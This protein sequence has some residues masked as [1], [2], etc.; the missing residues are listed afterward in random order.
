MSSIFVYSPLRYPGGKAAMASFFKK[1]ISLNN[2]TSDK[3]IYCEPYAGGA[4]VA[5]T[6]LLDGNV[7]QIIINDYDPCI[8]SFWYSILKHNEVF[9]QKIH[10][11]EISL[12][13]WH[14]Q[15]AYYDYMGRR[16]KLNSEDKINLG[17]ATFFL[18][19]CN[20]AGIL[21]KAGP[22]GGKKPKEGGYPIDAR[23]NKKALINR[24]INIGNHKNQ[25]R[26]FS[27]DAISFLNNLKALGLNKKETFIYLDPPYYIKGKEL[28]LNFYQ[29]KDHVKLAKYMINF[30]YC[31]WLMT[32]DKCNPI[33]TMYQNPK[34][35]VNDLS[36][37]YFMQDVR[38]TK[39]IL[40]RP[41][42]TVI[43]FL[44]ETRGKD[45]KD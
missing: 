42:K 34:I 35:V 45:K 26:L 37:Q 19:R 25:I 23:F 27:L 40:I 29:H 12:N 13:E 18:N 11:C 10:D 31:K 24:I 1:L 8:A 14:K 43:P 28:Y 39:E 41:I 4:G 44:G 20:R 16:R 7:N 33:K 6:L 21:P 32:Y 30:N 38:K 17:F 2:I 5:L 36:I 22:I 9:I 15:R 3:G